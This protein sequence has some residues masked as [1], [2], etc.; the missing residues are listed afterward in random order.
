MNLSIICRHFPHIYD[1]LC[2]T[3]IVIFYYYGLVLQIN[4][5]H[6]VDRD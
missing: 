5:F 1:V 2:L 3:S 4:R 6:F